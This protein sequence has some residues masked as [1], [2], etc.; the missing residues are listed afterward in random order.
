MRE[1][2]GEGA[3]SLGSLTTDSLSPGAKAAT[4]DGEVI[5]KGVPFDIFNPSPSQ[6]LRT[7][8]S[9]QVLQHTTKS[10]ELVHPLDFVGLGRERKVLRLLDGTTR[11]N[12]KV[13][14]KVS[15]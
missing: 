5:R 13:L 14:L 6:P 4:L 3:T 7:S 9:H 2:Q 8:A 11:L 10:P 12:P 15:C 1:E